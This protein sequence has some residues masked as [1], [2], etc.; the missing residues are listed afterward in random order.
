MKLKILRLI[1]RVL[2]ALRINV[3]T[4]SFG[5][6]GVVILCYH[7]F[8]EDGT[9]SVGES[10]E[11]RH[12]AQS[13]FRRQLEYLA[14]QGRVVDLQDALGALT[15][16]EKIAT[17]SAV[18]QCQ[19]KGRLNQTPSAINRQPARRMDWRISRPLRCSLDRDRERSVCC[20]EA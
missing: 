9:P 4:R 8:R 5:R 11:G 3:I 15:S 16:G 18:Q 10:H 1:L 12:L 17:G 6:Q 19:E 13:T 20:L 14:K 2:I 7:G